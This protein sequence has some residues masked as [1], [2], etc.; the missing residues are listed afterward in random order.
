[1][2]S[3]SAPP[4]FTSPHCTQNDDAPASNSTRFV[5]G[6]FQVAWAIFN[7]ACQTVPDSG[8]VVATPGPMPGPDA[9]QSSP[10]VRHWSASFVNDEPVQFLV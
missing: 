4:G 5:I 7:G 9:V 1:M 8:D 10:G 2:K 3:E 6:E